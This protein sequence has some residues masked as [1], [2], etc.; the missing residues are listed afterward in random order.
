MRGKHFQLGQERAFQVDS[1]DLRG[2]L[3]AVAAT[4][5]NVPKLQSHF[6]LIL[7]TEEA[8]EDVA[9]RRYG[10]LRGRD[11]SRRKRGLHGR[12]IGNL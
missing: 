9:R 6:R 8:L 3:H 5:V 10:D 11:D 2:A 7:A 1:Q 4:A 12:R